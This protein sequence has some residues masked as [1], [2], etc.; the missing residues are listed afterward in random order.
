MN[1]III[2]KQK[3]KT[4]QKQVIF[5]CIILDKIKNKTADELLQENH[6]SSIPPIDI[7]LLLKNIGIMEIPYDFSKIE[8]ILN[9]QKGDISGIIYA[10]KD[11]LGIFYCATDSLN[12]IR[13]TLA[14][15][16][17]HCCLHAESLKTRHIE[18]RSNQNKN[19]PKEY[20]ANI[21]A[22]ELLIPKTSLA[23]VYDQFIVA[24]PLSALSK[25]FNV[26]TSVMAARLDYLE[27]PYIKDFAE[28]GN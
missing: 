21:F 24:P 25:I 8:K 18:L 22:G 4:L 23:K 19:D 17:A 2:F 14:H 12:R 28:N 11:S 9:Y 27:M 5:M 13:F 16:I 7:S 6:I 15:E 26:S 3:K 10:K 1:K 20:A